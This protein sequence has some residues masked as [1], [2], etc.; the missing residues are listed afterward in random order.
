[1]IIDLFLRTHHK[2]VLD[3]AERDALEAAFVRTQDFTAKQ[4]VVREQ[5]PLTQCTLLL[6]G[7]VERYK[8]LPDGRRQILA[9]HVPGDFVDLH[10][11]PLK[12]L[13]HSVAALTAI[14][15]AFVPHEAVRALTKTSAT[16]TELLWRSTLIDA[17]INRE[18]IVSVGARGAAVRLAHL[19]CEMNVRLQRIGL[20]DGK[21]FVFPV[22]QIDLA[23]A[24][25][26]TAVH[27]NRMLRQLREDGLVEFRG[28]EVF[29][30]DA[31]ALRR[32]AG[33]DPGYL[34]ID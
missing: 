19:F 3:A 32:F 13:E 15:V 11:Y 7:F 30:P 16:L 29:I 9:I 18:W 34:F 28:G 31:D 5:V 12:K 4:I 8:D 25:G 6:D 24:T 20:S 14:R 17:A 27:A 23:D 10:S 22:T 26:L 2:P 33:F 21:R 1:M